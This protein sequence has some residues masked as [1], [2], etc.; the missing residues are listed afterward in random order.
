LTSWST[1]EGKRTGMGNVSR[2]ARCSTRLET[3]EWW[4]AETQRRQA[5]PA[6]I[7]CRGIARGSRSRADQRREPP[8]KPRRSLYREKRCRKISARH[9]SSPPNQKRIGTQQDKSEPEHNRPLFR[10]RFALP[11]IHT[12]PPTVTLP[13]CSPTQPA[14]NHNSRR[15][16]S[17]MNRPTAIIGTII[18]AMSTAMTSAAAASTPEPQGNCPVGHVC[19]W[20][21]TNYRGQVQIYRNPKWHTCGLI[22]GNITARS[23]TN[24]DNDTWTFFTNNNCTGA[25]SALPPGG[26]SRNIRGAL[27]WR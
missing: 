16:P 26:S 22:P 8:R 24:R 9:H 7:P 12:H 19:F 6:A 21:E 11:G 5:L 14:N 10:V 4:R 15:A 13:S 20:P 23:V 1:S 25:A 2:A 17:R 18:I 27:S 3:L